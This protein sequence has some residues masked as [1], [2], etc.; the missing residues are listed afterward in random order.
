MNDNNFLNEPCIHQSEIS[1]QV[2]NAYNKFL[3]CA[4]KL[5]HFNQSSKFGQTIDI[6]N[7]PNKYISASVD[8][9]LINNKN[10]N[11]DEMNKNSRYSPLKPHKIMLRFLSL[12]NINFDYKK[13]NHQSTLSFNG[14]QELDLKNN[15][16]KSFQ[17]QSSS[18]ISS[19]NSSMASS[20]NSYPTFSVM[21]SSSSASSIS[22]ELDFM[23][24]FK[25]ILKRTQIKTLS[26]NRVD[27][28]NV[29]SNSSNCPSSFVNLNKDH[30]NRRAKTTTAIHIDDFPNSNSQIDHNNYVIRTPTTSAF[31]NNSIHFDLGN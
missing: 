11:C 22:I 1:G 12:P 15:R 24:Q 18:S 21:T 9:L 31:S 25:D 19:T 23:K 4:K 14:N 20:S 30:L 17:N 26:K 16:T 28:S 5:K 6:K 7:A 10:D 13:S 29:R 27:S 8:L 3:K 2:L